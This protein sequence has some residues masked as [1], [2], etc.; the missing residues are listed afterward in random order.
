ML[1]VVIALVLSGIDAF[2]IPTDATAHRRHLVESSNE[3]RRSTVPLRR[4]APLTDINGVFDRD[5]AHAATVL[6]RNKHRQNL[7]NLVNNFGPSALRKGAVIKPLAVLPRDVEDRFAARAKRQAEPLV[8]EEDDS[9]WAGTISIGI[10]AQRFL[11]DFDTGSADLWVPSIDCTSSTCLKKSKYNK[12]ASLTSQQKNGTFLIEY[13]DQSTVSGKIYTDIVSV[14]GV[15]APGQY[16]S[17]VTNL[18]SSFGDNPID[19]VLGLA[20]PALSRLKHDPYFNTAYANRWLPPLLANQYAFYLATT[21]SELYLGGTNRIRY[22]GDIEFHDISASTG[23]WQIGGASVQ[24]GHETAVSSFETVIDSGTTIMYGPPDAVEK[25]Y[26]NVPGSV[27]YDSS[28]GTGF[29]SFPCNSI[30]QVSF[31][32]G[33]QHWSI[34]TANFNIGT[35]AEDQTRC[36]GAL[37]ASDLGLGDAVWLLGDSFMKNQYSV[38]DFDK[39]AVGFATLARYL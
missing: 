8:D 9:E 6:T 13:G 3:D 25:V 37:A 24:V 10:P 38:F 5:R 23:F 19:G 34:S 14:A 28:D 32:W 30:P 1:L 33:G 16:F 22:T 27:L 11:I 35:T 2:R 29:Y 31:S 36:V 12:S 20:F 17:A 39:K 4:R 18:S 26:A 7:I 15:K 21:G